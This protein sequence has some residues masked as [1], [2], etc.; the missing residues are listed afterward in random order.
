MTALLA[1]ASAR[2]VAG[3][4]RTMAGAAAAGWAAG[5]G[6]L[7]PTVVVLLAWATPDAGDFG[8]ATAVRTAGRVWLTAHGVSMELPDGRF[9]LVPLGLTALQ[10]WLLYTAAGWAAVRRGAGAGAAGAAR[11]TA[12]LAVAYG[13]VVAVTAL[14]TDG[15]GIRPDRV[16]ALTHGCLFALVA[17]GTGVLCRPGGHG[18]AAVLPA[19]VR[20][21]PRL[22]ELPAVLAGAAGAVAVLVGG[23]A[24]LAALSLVAH[25]DRAREL[26]EA[27]APGSLGTLVLL[28]LCV[29]LVPNLAVWGAAYAAGPGFAVGAG[30]A[31][32]PTG[33]ALGAVPV[34]P[35]LAALP[36]RTPP[37]PVAWAP[38]VLPLAAGIVA[39]L[40]AVRA[41]AA[42]AAGA[43][44]GSGTGL[45]AALG[46][47]A[48]VLA[49]AAMALLAALSGG[50]AGPGRM[51]EVGPAPL[52]VGFA[53]AV[54]VGLVAAAA[55]GAAQ[56]WRRSRVTSA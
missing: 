47:A 4:P 8:A 25:L 21:D 30:T 38:F 55:A 29:A 37:V 40:L 44:P 52:P 50:Q 39:G 41:S 2:V 45:A 7:A 23:G 12:E 28:L 49:G 48:G 5:V 54:E 20:R 33:V 56:E 10:A 35:V 51:A 19:R 22:R 11:L 26:T 31:V 32:A 3:P 13:A 36:E 53:V 6:V 24:L 15:A 16:G 1:R 27:L 46:L 18:P 34:L 14:L 42:P 43:G 9:G 17:G